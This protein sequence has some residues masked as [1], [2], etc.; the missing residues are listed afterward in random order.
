MSAAIYLRNLTKVFDLPHEKQTSL[1]AAVL[2]FRRPT[3]E[4]LLALNDISLSIDHG[5]TVAIVGR[6]GSGKST[7]LRVISRVYRQSAGTVEVDGRLSTML[8][9]GAGIEPELT[10]RENIFFNGAIMGLSVPELRSKED[11]IIE[12]S[13]LDSFIDAP[14]KTYSNG[15]LLRLGFSI[16]VETDPDILLVDEVIAVG[17]AAFQEKCYRRIGEYKNA[18]RTIVFV[19]HDL[20]A[21]RAVASR[22]VWLDKGTVRGDGKVGAVIESYMAATSAHKEEA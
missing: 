12:F 6:N 17:D 5:E 18:G 4:K 19:T 22:A 11:R 16:A 21:A 1:K 2:S 15:M 14:A 3:T 13:E 7:L 10:G 8:D 9:L 20:V